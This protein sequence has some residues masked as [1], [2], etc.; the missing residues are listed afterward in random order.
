[1][2]MDIYLPYWWTDFDV[3]KA[4]YAALSILSGVIETIFCS[5]ML[6]FSAIIKVLF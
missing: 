6:R 3:L 1:M 5:R 4:Y 2:G